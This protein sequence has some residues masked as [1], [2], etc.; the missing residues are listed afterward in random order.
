MNDTLTIFKRDYNHGDYH[1]DD[2]DQNH[3]E[4]DDDDDDNDDD[5]NDDDDYDCDNNGNILIQNVYLYN[6]IS[7]HVEKN[8]DKPSRNITFFAKWL[9][10]RRM[11]LPYF[12]QIQ[13]IDARHQNGKASR[14][15]FLNVNNPYM[16]IFY[17]F[18]KYITP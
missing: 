10:G 5:G 3:G 13:F 16:R 18:A 6:S 1:S 8:S 15:G 7:G 9:N 4:H 2:D 14:N 12:I 17:P 11:L